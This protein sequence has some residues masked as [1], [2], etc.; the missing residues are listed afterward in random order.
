[1]CNNVVKT[2]FG[3]TRVAYT[4]SSSWDATV[5]ESVLA[6]TGLLYGCYF[7]QKINTKISA[8]SINLLG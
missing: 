5:V 3:C 6:G 7:P 1:M 4:E 8:D 2:S